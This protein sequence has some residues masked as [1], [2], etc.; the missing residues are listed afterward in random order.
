MN[1]TGHNIQA[2]L[3]AQLEEAGCDQMTPWCIARTPQLLTAGEKDRFSIVY[4]VAI[5]AEVGAHVDTR[6]ASHRAGQLAAWDIPIHEVFVDRS[7][8]KQGQVQQGYKK[9]R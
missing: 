6:L 5:L 2:L 9:W 1:R 8:M 4:A 7:P 3:Q